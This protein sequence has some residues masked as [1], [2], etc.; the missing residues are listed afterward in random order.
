M[1]YK[2]GGKDMIK[3]KSNPTINNRITAHYGLSNE[4]GPEFHNGI[5]LGAIKQG[6][7]GDPIFTVDSGKVIV[8]SNSPTAGNYLIVDHNNYFS[9]Y[10]HLK[11][12][13]KKVGDKVSAGETIGTMGN[14]GKSTAAHLH[15]E[16]KHGEY[17]EFWVKDDE[18]KYI[19]S[20]D[21]EPCFIKENHWAE[22]HFDSLYEK[23]I[24]IYEKKFDDYITRGEVMALLDR[25][26]QNKNQHNF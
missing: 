18:G 20:V 17:K 22:K 21:P 8:V 12:V 2:N 13:L 6:I 14:T 4:Y 23:G 1:K 5:D 11:K 24:I 10:L 15:L 25:I 7:E 3:F 26:V 16:I 9:R 19:N